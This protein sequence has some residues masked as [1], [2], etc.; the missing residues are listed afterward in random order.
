VPSAQRKLEESDS[1]D[2]DVPLAKKHAERAR[3]PSNVSPKLGNSKKDEPLPPKKRRAA[4]AKAL[5]AGDDV[6]DKA[7]SRTEVKQAAQVP[8]PTNPGGAGK[9]QML[10][11]K[12]A[13]T[14]VPRK[15]KERTKTMIDTTKCEKEHEHEPPKKRSRR[16]APVVGCVVF[17]FFF[18]GFGLILDSSIAAA[19]RK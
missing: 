4:K 14:N 13:P 12:S 15:R 1:D 8:L 7:S 6:P 11:E 3:L 2:S 16:A 9:V 19:E 17:S 10:Q 18:S 5:P